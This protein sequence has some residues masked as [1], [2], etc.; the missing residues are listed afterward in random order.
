MPFEADVAVIGG[1][2]AGAVAALTLAKLGMRTILLEGRAVPIW[3][4]GETLAPESR[5]ILQALGVWNQF[6]KDGHLPS[7]GNCSVW[8]SDDIL[9]KDFI[10]NPHGCAF[11]L[12]RARF[13]ELLQNAAENAGSLVWRDAPVQSFERRREGWDLAAGKKS[14]RARWLIDASGRRSIVARRLGFPRLILDRLVAIYALGAAKR[15]NDQ[16]NRTLIEA[17]PDGWW[18]T[19]RTPSGQRTLAL[20]T[21]AELLARQEWRTSGWLLKRVQKTLHLGSILETYGYT[22][23]TS[24]RLT[25]AHSGRIQPYHG[26]GWLAVGDAAQSFDPISGQG[27]FAA[28]LSGKRAARAL[29]EDWPQTGTALTEYALWLEWLWKRFLNDRRAYYETERRW[30]HHSFWQRT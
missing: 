16:D 29:A 3:K 18:Y 1:G 12:N 10:F 22:F 21:D 15:G 26:E 2:P 13:E 23:P 5:Q 9:F 20:Q 30:P 17:R 7:V 14:L 24:P 27:I 4:I 25:S 28:L 11:Q 8:G 19:A 6:E